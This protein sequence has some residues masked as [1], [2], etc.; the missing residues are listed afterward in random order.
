[1]GLRKLYVMRVEYISYGRKSIKVFCLKFP[2]LFV[3]LGKS[4]PLYLGTH[5]NHSM[6]SAMLFHVAYKRAMGIMSTIRQILE[7]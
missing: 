7:E 2:T 6:S 4:T 3:G 1:V 5:R